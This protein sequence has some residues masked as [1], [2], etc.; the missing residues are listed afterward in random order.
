MALGN[1]LNTSTQDAKAEF[2]EVIDTAP[3]P[4]PCHMSTAGQAHHRMLFNTQEVSP[5]WEQSGHSWPRLGGH[6]SSLPGVCHALPR[7]SSGARWAEASS[8]TTTFPCYRGLSGPRPQKHN[9]LKC[10]DR[11]TLSSSVSNPDQGK[12]RGR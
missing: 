4:S 6:S 9:F 5:E 12:E 1:R 8:S 3:D 7:E 10:S 2:S 11:V